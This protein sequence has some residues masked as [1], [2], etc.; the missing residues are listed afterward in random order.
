[1]LKEVEDTSDLMP[2]HF[3]KPSSVPR[4]MEPYTLDVTVI[5]HLLGLEKPSPSKV[6]I[7][8]PAVDPFAAW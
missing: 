7:V 6:I 5:G 1:L 4:S 3:V 8:P 2:L